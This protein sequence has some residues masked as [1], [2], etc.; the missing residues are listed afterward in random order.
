[1]LR[2]RSLAL[3]GTATAASLLSSALVAS[4][5]ATASAS[6]PVP[7]A[8]GSFQVP[9]GTLAVPSVTGSDHYLNSDSCPDA[10][11]CMAVGDYHLCGHIP[12]MSA[13]LS[14]GN[15]VAE[16][17]PSPSRGLN[18]FTNQVSCS[19]A[20]SCL[21]VGDHWAGRRDVPFADLSESWN[22]SSWSIVMA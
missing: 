16:P 17:V 6:S 19:S 5:P 11:F 1:M 13:M 20:T 21:F 10:T 22:G 7:S 3:V 12:A 14:A 18:I 4:A 2:L 9:P 15:W 8:R